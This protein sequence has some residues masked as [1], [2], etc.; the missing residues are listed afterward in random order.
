M[1]RFI[2]TSTSLLLTTLSGFA[3]TGVQLEY[4]VRPFMK[5]YCYTC[6]GEEKQK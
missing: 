2:T 6:H 5:Q 1:N 3:Y 4:E